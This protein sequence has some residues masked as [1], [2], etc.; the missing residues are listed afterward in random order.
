MKQGDAAFSYDQALFRLFVV[1]ITGCF[2]VISYA[3]L[4]HWPNVVAGFVAA[5][6]GLM[7]SGAALLLGGLI[8][9]LFGVPHLDSNAEASP[10]VKPGSRKNGGES[11]GPA[12][13]PSTSLEQIS[14]WLTK[15]IVGIGLVE[16]KDI[17]TALDRVGRQLQEGMGD[18]SGKN[19]FSVGLIL[20]FLICGFTFGFLWSRLY[21]VGW[22]READAVESLR[23]RVSKIEQRQRSDDETM[24]FLLGLI[25]SDEDSATPEDDIKRAVSEASAAARQQIFQSAHDASA[26]FGDKTQSI[27]FK[28][29]LAILRARVESDKDGAHFEYRGEL[30]YALSRK[31][32]PDI[33]EAEKQMS[34]AIRLRDAGRHRGWRYYEMR[35]ARYLAQL[36][37]ENSDPAI[38][39]KIMR[40][41][42]AA[43]RDKEKWPGWVASEHTVREWMDKNSLSEDLTAKQ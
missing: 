1:A 3:T 33:V 4:L 37:P 27:N 26:K 31:R 19:A 24:A 35:R 8:G 28:V 34:E 16:F 9:F 30:S 41:L 23:G 21:L 29:I 42:R 39:E 11:S 15:I 13:M 7:G 18:P 36:D 22:F 17:G 38:R 12:Y 14:D 6:V 43:Q 20:Y 40:D 10:S 32:P 2:F 25:N 5:F